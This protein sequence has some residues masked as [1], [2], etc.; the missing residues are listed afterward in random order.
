MALGPGQICTSIRCLARDW[1]WTD[2]KTFSYLKAL[3]EDESVKRETEHE[4]KH[5][6]KQAPTVLTICNWSYYQG[7]EVD[8]SNAKP[9]TNS[10]TERN[11][12]I[13][14]SKNANK[15][16]N[17]K[18]PPTPLLEDAVEFPPLWGE[19]A[20]AAF[21]DWVE[22]RRQLKKPLLPKT[23]R[24]LVATYANNPRAF[25]AAV[26]YTINKGIQGL[27]EDPA[28]KSASSHKTRAEMN[29]ER[30]MQIIEQS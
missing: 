23:L 12:I 4:F 19:R 20:Q 30:D 24:S 22:Y 29:F 9:N 6:A 10:N 8:S 1:G 18:N 16:A 17:K 25:A 14:G 7:G 3:E 27:I 5:E 26:T 11:A 2:Y 13:K 28:F 21:A 15:N